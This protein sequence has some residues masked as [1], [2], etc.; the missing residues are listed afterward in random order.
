VVTIDRLSLYNR[1][2]KKSA[3]ARGV[4]IGETGQQN[5]KIWGKNDHCDLATF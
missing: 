1:Y 4:L 2:I 5:G 3:R